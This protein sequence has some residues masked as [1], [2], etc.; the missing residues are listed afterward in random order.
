MVMMIIVTSHYTNTTLCDN[1]IDA[2][3]LAVALVWV[4]KD[5]LGIISSLVFAYCCSERCVLLCMCVWGCV[6]V[7]VCVLL[8]M[9]V[10]GCVCCCCVCVYGDVCDDDTYTL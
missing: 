9:C 8:C 6:S 1:T 5:G 10:W 7:C 4:I 2:S 3:P